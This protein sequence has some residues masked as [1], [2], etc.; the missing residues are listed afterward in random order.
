[1]VI[2]DDS[3]AGDDEQA[4]HRDKGKGKGKKRAS[5]QSIA[6]SKKRRTGCS[7]F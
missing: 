5:S 2:N 3:D 6:A 7:S 4:S 1:M